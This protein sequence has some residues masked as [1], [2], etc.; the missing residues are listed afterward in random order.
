MVADV[1]DAV[2]GFYTFFGTSG[3]ASRI[4]SVIA[5][6]TAYS[7]VLPRSWSCSTSQTAAGTQ[8]MLLRSSRKTEHRAARIL[9]GFSQPTSSPTD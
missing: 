7:T 6:P 2:E 9:I 8:M 5:N 3:S 1:D 4:C